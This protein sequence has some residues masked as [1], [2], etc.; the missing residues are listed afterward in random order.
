MCFTGRKPSST[1][2]YFSN[3]CLKNPFVYSNKAV[4]YSAYAPW[5]HC[6]EDWNSG[7]GS[8]LHTS[9]IQLPPFSNPESYSAISRDIWTICNCKAMWGGCRLPLATVYSTLFAVALVVF[10]YS[11]DCR[12]W[13]AMCSGRLPF[14]VKYKSW[15]TMCNRDSLYFQFS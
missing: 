4:S 1:S 6:Q 12:S 15:P 13:P 14:P 2:V 9:Q 5:S 10:L 7:K 11:K 8:L 3:S